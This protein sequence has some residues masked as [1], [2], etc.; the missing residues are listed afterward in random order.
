MW[1]P[2]EPAFGTK[3][4]T[5]TPDAAIAAGVGADGDCAPYVAFQLAEVGIPRQQFEAIVDR[6]SRLRQVTTPGTSAG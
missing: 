1:R 4:A 6:I 3:P 2:P 5:D